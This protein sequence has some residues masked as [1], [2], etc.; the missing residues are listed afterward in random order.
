M[1]NATTKM[2][3]GLTSNKNKP[4]SNGMYSNFDLARITNL[5]VSTVKRYLSAAGVS[6]DEFRKIPTRNNHRQSFYNRESQEKFFD[7][8][9]GPRDVAK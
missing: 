6:A 8:L 2:Y 1:K 5:N 3:P 4:S 7:W 9:C